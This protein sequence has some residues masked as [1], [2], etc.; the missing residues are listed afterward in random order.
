MNYLKTLEI[1]KNMS[2]SSTGSRWLPHKTRKKLQAH[3][4]VDGNFFAAVSKATLKDYERIVT[5]ARKAFEVW[6]A[7]P[8]PKRGDIVRQIGLRLR[9]FKQPLGT[10]ISY[11]SGK[12]IQEG[13]GEV[14]E[15][16]DIC[17]FCVGQSRMLYGMTSVSERPNHRLFEQYHPWELWQL[18][19]LLTSR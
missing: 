3:S 14:Q 12:P 11:E 2:G 10:L 9:E 4:P 16:I 19:L 8:A 5:T 18:S 13:L 15:L 6:R 7:T 17:D 1:T